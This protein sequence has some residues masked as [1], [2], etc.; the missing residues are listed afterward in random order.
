MC[1]FFVQKNIF[2]AK[3]FYESALRS[4]VIFGSKSL[5]KNAGKTLMKLTVGKTYNVQADFWIKPL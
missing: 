3:I 2:G 4:F 1:V 5:D